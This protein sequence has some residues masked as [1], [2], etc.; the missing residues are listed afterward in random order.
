MQPR[1]DRYG[2]APW[3]GGYRYL[4]PRVFFNVACDLQ[5]RLLGSHISLMDISLMEL[6]NLDKLDKTWKNLIER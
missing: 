3:L 4:Q 6:I 1:Q 5:G 2:E